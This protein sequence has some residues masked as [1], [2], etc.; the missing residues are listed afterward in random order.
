MGTRAF[1]LCGVVWYNAELAA[2]SSAAEQN[3]L[4]FRQ[5][6][7]QMQQQ[8]EVQMQAQKMQQ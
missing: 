2:S 5:Q 7:Q 4:Q 8:M 6:Q 3:V 1:Q